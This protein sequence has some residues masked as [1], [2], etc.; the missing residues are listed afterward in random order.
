MKSLKYLA[1]LFLFLS[2]TSCKLSRFVIYNFADITDYKIFPART[3][4]NDSTVY[5]Y[6]IA[7]KML[8]PKVISVK[9][10]EYSFEEYLKDNETVAFLIIRN[11][12]IQY[13]KYWHKYDEESIVASFSMAKSVTSI[14]IGC[15]IDEGLIESVD[16][17][18]TNYIP[19]LKKRGFDLVTIEHL[20][21]MTSGLKF[22]ESYY[23]PFGDVATSYYGTNMR[24]Q[25][26]K[27]KLKQSPGVEFEYL[28]GN[29]EL[30]GLVLER[31]LNDRSISE[32]L[33]EKLWGPLGMEYDATWSLDKEKNGLEKAFCC[34]NAR[35]R[36]FAKIG[37]LYKNK[38][39]W[40][41]HQIVS[42]EWVARSTMIDSTNGSIT[43]YQYQ[44][45]LPTKNG[46]FMAHGIL[47]QYIYV[48]PEKNFVVVRLG[49]KEGDADW[50]YILPRLAEIY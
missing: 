3:I 15:A 41:D 6:P 46:D 42:E 38:G 24:R 33:E 36:D 1:L 9:G 18:I 34:L 23:N 13:E 48:H 14:L 39:K 50:E 12:T 7:E 35:A 20:L 17:P 2:L 8:F 31:A 25:I 26:S 45:W 47:G 43:G 40:K 27:M 28:S 5:H 10:K 44:W 37:T 21:Q 22:N 30:L 11:D 49:K 32:Y 16:E 19:E 29:T 4:E